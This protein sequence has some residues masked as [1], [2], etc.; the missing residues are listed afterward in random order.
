MLRLVSDARHEPT[1]FAA[2]LDRAL[3]DGNQAKADS[4]HSMPVALAEAA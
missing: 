4:C 3:A 1:H 2:K